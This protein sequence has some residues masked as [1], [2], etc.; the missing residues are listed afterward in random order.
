M[1][2]DRVSSEEQMTGSH[3]AKFHTNED[4]QPVIADFL[5]QEDQDFDNQH[6]QQLMTTKHDT[7]HGHD[8]PSDP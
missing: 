2:I 4:K 5:S 1:S 7:D 3:I 6:D 8:N